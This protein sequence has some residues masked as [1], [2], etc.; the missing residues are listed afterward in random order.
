ML[1]ST[2]SNCTLLGFGRK[3]RLKTKKASAAAADLKFYFSP[4]YFLDFM[5]S[6]LF[7]GTYSSIKVIKS[8]SVMCR[9]WRSGLKPFITDDR[10]LSP[11]I[12]A[13]TEGLPEAPGNTALRRCTHSAQDGPQQMER[14]APSTGK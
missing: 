1:Q 12:F 4:E 2:E 6:H 8:V 13:P 14:A 7:Q 9:M 11:V 3:Q 10:A 5:L